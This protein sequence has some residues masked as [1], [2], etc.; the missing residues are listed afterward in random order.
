VIFFHSCHTE[1]I[2]GK[3]VVIDIFGDFFQ[4]PPNRKKFLSNGKADTD[5]VLT[6]LKSV[7]TELE[8]FC[9]FF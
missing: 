4:T 1:E 7:F 3:Q 2:V 9:K 6:R 5:K 8:F